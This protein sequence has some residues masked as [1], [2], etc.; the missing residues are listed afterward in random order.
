MSAGTVASYAFG[1]LLSSSGFTW[2]VEE[3]FKTVP[4]TWIAARRVQHHNGHPVP[5]EQGHIPGAG[6][7]AFTAQ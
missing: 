4:E 7:K 5:D 1:S 6:V 2:N 3:D